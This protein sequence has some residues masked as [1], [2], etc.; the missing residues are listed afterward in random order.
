MTPPLEGLPPK[1][2]SAC[3]LPQSARP[4]PSI[5]QAR[6]RKATKIAAYLAE[7]GFTSA[8]VSGW[9]QAEREAVARRAGQRSPSEKTWAVVLEKLTGRDETPLALVA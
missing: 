3:S 6:E 9:V 5:S 7:N 4:P 1:G 2:N 8:A